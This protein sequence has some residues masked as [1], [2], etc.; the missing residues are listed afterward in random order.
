MP[1]PPTLILADWSCFV[2]YRKK[3]RSNQT[4]SSFTTKPEPV[5]SAFPPATTDE[6]SSPISGPFL[7]LDTGSHFQLLQ[8]FGWQSPALS[9]IT[10]SSLSPGAFLSAS[11]LVPAPPILPTTW[12]FPTCFFIILLSLLASKHGCCSTAPSTRKLFDFVCTGPNC[13]AMPAKWDFF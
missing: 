10:G 9:H 3:H 8:D 1:S 13:E 4:S 7:H 2:F 12:Y 5:F 11:K 6:V